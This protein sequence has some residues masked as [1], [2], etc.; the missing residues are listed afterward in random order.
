[1]KGLWFQQRGVALISVLL[2]FALITIISGA[3][4][5]QSYLNTKRLSHYLNARQAYYYALAAEQLA[6]Q[7]LYRDI[8]EQGFAEVS[9]HVDS[10]DDE[11]AQQLEAF[12]IE[13]GHLEITITDLQAK[14]NLNDLVDRSSAQLRPAHVA[15]LARLLQQEGMPQ[16]HRDVILDWLDSD[17]DMRPQGAENDYYQGLKTPYATAGRGFVDLSE[18]SLLKGVSSQDV[19]A[20]SQAISLLPESTAININTASKQLL[21]VL[22]DSIS[23]SDVNAIL[24]DQRAGGFDSIEQWQQQSYA[25]ALTASGLPFAV[26]SSYFEV[27]IK[28]VYDGRLCRLKTVFYRSPESGELQVIKRQRD[29]L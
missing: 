1:M 18:L 9:V 22:S 25:A 19:L 29:T 20:L 4:L 8:H 17:N 3:M 13:E 5:K 24:A 12:S 23:G 21:A 2:I 28:S 26:A 14:L 27:Q 6:R 10:F 7:Y 11:W 16:G 15:V